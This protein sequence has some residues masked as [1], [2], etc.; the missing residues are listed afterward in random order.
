MTYEMNSLKEAAARRR[1]KRNI[2]ILMEA[3]ALWDSLSPER[4]RRDS[5]ARFV[6]KGDQWSDRVDLG[7]GRSIREDQWLAQQGSPALSHNLMGSM[8][9]RVM[10][11]FRA[12]KKDPVCITNDPEQQELGDV[13]TSAVA[14][15][16]VLNGKAE[17]D[18]ASLK[19]YILGAAFQKETCGWDGDADRRDCWTWKPS[20][21]RMFWDKTSTDPNYRDIRLIGELHDLSF[22][23]LVNEFAKT[24][25]DYQTLSGIYALARDTEYMTRFAAQYDKRDDYRTLDF[26]VTKD[27]HL[28]RVI[29][30]WRKEQ[31]PRYRCI[32]ALKGEL[33]K[34]EEEDL[35]AVVI[36]ENHRRRQQAE[37]CGATTW[38][39]ITYEWFIDNYWYVR[40]LSPFGDVLFE[41]ESPYAHRSH[42]YSMRLY[43]YVD[44]MS[45]S[46][47]ESMK[48]AQKMI[49]RQLTLFDLIERTSAKGVLMVPDDSISDKMSLREMSQQYAKVGGVVLFK[50]SKTGIK[51]EQISNKCTNIGL[52][53]LLQLELK[54]MEDVTGVHSALQGQAGKSGMSASLYMQ[55]TQNSALG[56]LDLLNSFD[57]FLLDGAKKKVAN[58]QQFYD[59]PRFIRVAG[60]KASLYYDPVKM[61]DLKVQVTMEES[62]TA[63]V[64]QNAQMVLMQ[65]FQQHAITVKQLLEEGKFSFSQSLLQSLAADEQRLAQGQMPEGVPPEVMQQ[66][67]QQSNPAMTQAI[68]AI[69]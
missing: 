50:P 37:R 19:D 8:T 16:N 6:F 11:E 51:P 49:N 29:E 60:R 28:C 66:I 36:A 53:D 21:N 14:A 24:P 42:P 65:L 4:K 69:A 56:L 38:Q 26:L 47:A 20:F 35:E 22:G 34:V 33:F 1:D 52:I 46:W 45:N 27:P 31:K 23:E 40:Y 9:T 12:N 54:M 18:A 25:E 63:S 59:E 13:L 39:P 67:Q 44:G 30:V 32:D 17:L 2:E 64:K 48:P 68:G 10:G 3:K 41:S 62:S 61:I 7:N 57:S 58:I 15:N 5:V 55:Q 43:N